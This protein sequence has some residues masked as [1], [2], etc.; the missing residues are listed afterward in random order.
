MNVPVAKA[1]EKGKFADSKF[2]QIEGYGVGLFR[3]VTKKSDKSV[4][5]LYDEVALKTNYFVH[6]ADLAVNDATGATVSD[7]VV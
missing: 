6:V 7:E 1:A 2:Y 5:A 3:R 4:V